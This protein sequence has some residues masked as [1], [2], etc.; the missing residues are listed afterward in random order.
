MKEA[1]T[2]LILLTKNKTI[3]HIYSDNWKFFNYCIITGI[4]VI[5]NMV[6]LLTFSNFIPLWLAN[7][8]AIGTAVIWNYHNSVGR[9][10]ESWGMKDE[11]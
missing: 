6:V 4:G 9:F 7:L 2:N 8:I 10:S 1:V 11:N 5:I 3:V